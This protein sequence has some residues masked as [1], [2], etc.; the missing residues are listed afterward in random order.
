M[1]QLLI[2]L[3]SFRRHHNSPALLAYYESMWDFEEYIDRHFQTE[4]DENWFEDVWMEDTSHTI[5]VPFKKDANKAKREQLE[6][7]TARYRE[8]IA[9]LKKSK[10]DL[11]LLCNV[12]DT[13]Q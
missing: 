2:P 3:K 7:W 8:A 12:K 1:E 11:G 10:G 4:F 13:I 9:L 6:L 5:G